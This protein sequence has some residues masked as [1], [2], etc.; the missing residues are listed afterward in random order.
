M[1]HRNAL[2]LNPEIQFNDDDDELPALTVTVK[3]SQR[4]LEAG[5]VENSVF[6]SRRNEDGS[7][8][9][10][11]IP[12]ESSMWS[13]LRKLRGPQRTVLVTGTTRVLSDRLTHSQQVTGCQIVRT[14]THSRCQAARCDAGFDIVF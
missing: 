13:I 1:V 11:A 2:L 7:W 5:S 3:Q 14:S 12:A 8:Q 10:I 9:Y 4:V 6:S